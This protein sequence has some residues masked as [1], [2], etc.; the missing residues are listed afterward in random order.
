[1]SDGYLIGVDTGGTYT[2]AAV[3]KAG[4]SDVMARA[5]ALTTRGDLAI[6]VSEAIERALEDLDETGAAG[7]VKLVSVSTTL[8]TNAVVEGHG[9]AVGVVLIG[10]DDTMVARTG[11]AEAFPGIAL[12]RVAG[13]HDHNGSAVAPLDLTELE[14]KVEIVA[15]SVDA[16]AV[17]GQFA[18]RNPAHEEAVREA[19]VRL[20][21]KPVTLS[22]ELSSALDAPRRAL[23][24][25]LNARLIARIST[26]IE[27]VGRSM[28]RFGISAPLMIVKGDGT[29]ALAET[30]AMRP[31]ET[32]LSGPAASLV[33]AAALSE[34]Q[35]FILSDMGG[36]TTD[37]GFLKDGRPMVS[38][39]GAEVG[40]WR[41]MVK[42]IDART[43]GLGGD[44]EVSL[45]HTGELTVG[46]RRVVPLSLLGARYGEVV[47]QLEAELSEPSSGIMGR[48]ALLPM[49][50]SGAGVKAAG[51]SAR[52]EALLEQVSERPKTLSRIAPSNALQRT[53]ASLQRKGLIQ[54]G[55]FT[56]SDAAHVL[57]LQ[58]NW[59]RPAA[60]IGARIMA[61]IRNE[62]DTGE[63]GAVRFSQ[64]VWD[65]AVTQSGKAIVEALLPGPRKPG[66][67]AIVEA[68]CRGDGRLGRALVSVTPDVPIVAVG[69]PVKVYYGEVARRLGAEVV[70]SDY[71]DVANAVGAASGVI[72]QVVQLEISG[73]GGGV[74][75][76]M[77]LDG[78]ETFRSA[79]LAIGR[80]REK[81]SDAARQA[82][83]DMGAG[84]AELRVSISKQMLPD[85][86]DDNGL[87][88]AQVVVE[89]VGRPSL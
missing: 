37:L 55:G 69:G 24:A 48:F 65:A 59:S 53:L 23:T 61:R 9:S 43:V 25:V 20:T 44:S 14:A 26:L 28:D 19:I 66:D 74:F 79:T 57:D 51:L 34:L 22:S 5:K 72:A 4:T 71:C 82:V 80:A 27:A 87:L 63:D 16:F 58:D 78:A 50:S 40:G 15:R 10:F 31:I 11:I 6:G 67:A 17:A 12:I 76:V 33:G 54:I 3:L 86:V 38:E 75:R 21:G 60:M 49:G 83:L 7:K 36:T 13:G 32:I 62:K 45:H 56:P 81:A 18:V 30:V 89:A 1:M 68:V 88:S 77:G 73:D 42:A 85:A 46:P 8:A 64:A 35:D 29:L 41:T 52:E 39:L 70:F 2:D 84:E 47:T